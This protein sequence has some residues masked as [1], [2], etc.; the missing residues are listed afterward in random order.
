MW[1]SGPMHR[2]TL[3][4]N[5]LYGVNPVFASSVG[6]AD[7]DNGNKLI[8]TKLS[9]DHSIHDTLSVVSENHLSVSL[10]RNYNPKFNKVQQSCKFKIP[11]Y[12][13]A[14]YRQQLH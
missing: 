8:I 13:Q 6:L 2:N 11:T 9:D 12:A 14:A 5:P 7:Q 10:L 1:F 4:K 3:L